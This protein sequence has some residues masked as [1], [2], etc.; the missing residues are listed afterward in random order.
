MS[1]V[2]DY[3]KVGGKAWYLPEGKKRRKVAIVALSS[4][5]KGFVVVK[6]KTHTFTVFSSSLEPLDD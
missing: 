2:S 4:P 5:R 3:Y 1:T 6:D